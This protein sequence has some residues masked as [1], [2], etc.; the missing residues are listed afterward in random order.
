MKGREVE[1]YLGHGTRYTEAKMLK[2]RSR[3][4]EAVGGKST[5]SHIKVFRFST[6]EVR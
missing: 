3:E 1:S 5:S 4:S 6:K 2:L